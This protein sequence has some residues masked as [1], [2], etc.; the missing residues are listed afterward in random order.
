MSQYYI[1]TK[2]VTAVEQEKD[3]KPG[4]AVKYPDGYTS[5]SPK[6]VFEAAYLKQG[7]DGSRVTQKMVDDFIVSHEA[8]RMGNHAVVRVK[9]R[10]GFSLIA[11]SAC[12][13]SANY[14]QE[15]GERLA[16]EKAKNQVWYLLGFMLASARHGVNNI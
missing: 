8:Y 7:N 13:D 11:E 9:L 10:N 1:G 16:L 14:D 15:I 12:V 5:W 3:G 2:Q 6:E 4:Y